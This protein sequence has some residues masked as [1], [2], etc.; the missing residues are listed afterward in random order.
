M[1]VE[2]LVLINPEVEII[3]RLPAFPGVSTGVVYH[4]AFKFHSVF[5]I[6]GLISLQDLVGQVGHVNACIAFSCEVEIVFFHVRK[7]RKESQQ[8]F[9]VIFCCCTVI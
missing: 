6:G 7:F 4:Y 3:A 2:V 8:S 1:E 9:I 5:G